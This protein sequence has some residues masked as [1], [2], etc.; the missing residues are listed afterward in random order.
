MEL[1][2]GMNETDSFTQYVKHIQTLPKLKSLFACVKYYLIQNQQTSSNMSCIILLTV[3]YLLTVIATEDQ[4][5]YLGRLFMAYMEFFGNDQ[6]FH[7][8]PNYFSFPRFCQS[9]C[10]QCHITIDITS[11]QMNQSLRVLF[12]SNLHCRNLAKCVK[13]HGTN[14][15]P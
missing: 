12:S 2:I 10:D 7:D 8:Q 14:Y 3:V 5:Q 15:L 4:K 13:L 1:Q 11:N 6:H 9:I